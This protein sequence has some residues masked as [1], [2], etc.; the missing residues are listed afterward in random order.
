MSDLDQRQALAVIES[1]GVYLV[2]SEVTP[3]G[4]YVYHYSDGTKTLTPMEPGAGRLHEAIDALGV[5]EHITEPIATFARDLL[6]CHFTT[7]IDV[8]K[9]YETEGWHPTA[10]YNDIFVDFHTIDLP[11]GW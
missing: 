11:G 3:T 10:F 4:T 9:H 2:H 6:K 5:Y 8:S 1:S 7:G